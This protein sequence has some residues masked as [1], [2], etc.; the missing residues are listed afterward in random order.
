MTSA[1]IQY[2]KGVTKI[3][4]TF[5]FKYSFTLTLKGNS[6]VVGK[7]IGLI[8]SNADSLFSL[9]VAGGGRYLPKT[10]T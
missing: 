8:S 4:G 2:V 9:S 1:Q 5:P 6:Y 3:D 10:V 7:L